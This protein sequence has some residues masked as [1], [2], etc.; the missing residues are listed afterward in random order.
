MKKIKILTGSLELTAEL[1]ETPT[2]EAIN[3]ALPLEGEIQKWGDEIYLFHDQ[4]WYGL[5]VFVKQQ[6]DIV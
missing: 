1:I 6:N 4:V 3:D 2:A 5:S